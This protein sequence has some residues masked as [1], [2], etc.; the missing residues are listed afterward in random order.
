MVRQE[1]PSGLQGSLLHREHQKVMTVNHREGE[2]E[3]GGRKKRERETTMVVLPLFGIRGIVFIL[4]ISLL[5]K[6]QKV[7]QNK[8]E[9]TP[10][11]PGAFSQ[12]ACFLRKIWNSFASG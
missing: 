12:T 6:F 9:H 11:R 10:E 7:L 8:C 4:F 3:G 1:I 2:E 5:K